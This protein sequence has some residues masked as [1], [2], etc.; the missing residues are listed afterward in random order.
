[1][2]DLYLPSRDRRRMRQSH[3]R[4]GKCGGAEK[5]QPKISEAFPYTA[6]KE[7]HFIVHIGEPSYPPIRSS[8]PEILLDSEPSPAFTIE[9]SQHADKDALLI[10]A[11]RLVDAW[12]EEKLEL[13]R[14]RDDALARTDQTSWSTRYPITSRPSV[15]ATIIT[16]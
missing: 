10:D 12:E 2:E 16:V 14:A 4:R 13:K 7:L 8:T 15:N 11:G 5:R 6:E 1:M 9:N 3:K